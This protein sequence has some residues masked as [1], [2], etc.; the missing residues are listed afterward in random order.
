MQS[1]KPQCLG[2]YSKLWDN[3]RTIQTLERTGIEK[4][5]EPASKINCFTW[6]VK[7]RNFLHIVV[8]QCALVSHSMW[9]AAWKEFLRVVQ[10]SS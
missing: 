7:T 2:F 8:F 4:A 5:Q 3:I 1:G 9:L 6:R 10:P